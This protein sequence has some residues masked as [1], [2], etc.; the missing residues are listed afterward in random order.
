MT[1]Q[2]ITK[3]FKKLLESDSLVQGDDII[4]SSEKTL[5]TNFNYPIAIIKSD[6]IGI[7]CLFQKSEKAKQYI[8]RL[9]K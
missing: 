1:K 9:R 3:R 5:E 7:Y 8:I 4:H 6:S 2:K